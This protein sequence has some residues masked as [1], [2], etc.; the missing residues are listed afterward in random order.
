MAAAKAAPSDPLMS[1]T[2]LG[3]AGA[4]RMDKGST[5]S[6]SYSISLSMEDSVSLACKTSP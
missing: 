3:P 1:P 6:S 4:P 2:A 5:T